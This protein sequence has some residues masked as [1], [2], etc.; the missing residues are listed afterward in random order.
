MKKDTLELP[1]T[2]FAELMAEYFYLPKCI[3][4][5]RSNGLI[6]NDFHASI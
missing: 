6:N 2:G 3:K 1:K 4:R 5:N